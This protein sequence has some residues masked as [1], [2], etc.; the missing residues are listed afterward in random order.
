MTVNPSAV[1]R[2]RVAGNNVNGGGYDAGISGAGTDYSQQDAAQVIGTHGTAT[3]TTAFTDTT[4]NNFTSAMVG[5]SVW[6]ASGAGFTV[7]CYFVVGFTS[8]S[9]ITLDRSPGTGTVAVWKLG[10]AWADPQTNMTTATWIVPGCT[11]YIRGAGSNN[12]S[13]A[14]YTL[15]GYVVPAAGDATN[16]YITYIGENGRPKISGTGLMFFQVGLLKF[17]NIVFTTTGANNANFGII[18]CTGLCLIYNCAFDQNGYDIPGA[19]MLGAVIKSEFY[20]S[21]AAR[22]TKT[23]AAV[24]CSD[25]AVLVSNCNVHDVVGPGIAAGGMFQ[26][27]NNLIVKCGADGIT[28]A[29]NRPGYPGS[30]VGNTIDGNTGNGIAIS[31]TVALSIT[32]IIGNIISNHTGAGMAG[33]AYTGGATSAQAARIV[34]GWEGNAYYNNT[35]HVSGMAMAGQD[36]TVNVD[37]QFINT[38][39]ENYGLGTNL[40][41]LGPPMAGNSMAGKVASVTTSYPGAIQMAAV[42]GAVI[43]LAMVILLA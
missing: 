19:V 25:F 37:P 34:G 18:Y 8:S 3:G 35:S 20:S 4:A 39:T 16:G 26:V 29:D 1:Y 24:V 6:I 41:G 43:T 9:A 23:Y 13:S 42:V 11:I 12:P 5:N 27:L 31:Q 7:G 2:V 21:V 36:N 10:G 33:I 40:R 28:L 32:R 15:G 22:S 14:D 30:I 17:F 38:T